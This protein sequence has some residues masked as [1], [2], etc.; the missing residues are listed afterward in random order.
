MRKAEKTECAD[1]HLRFKKP[2]MHEVETT[3]K[4]T[5]ETVKTTGSSFGVGISAASKGKR[6]NPRFSTRTYQGK[7][8][9]W[10]CNEC[11]QKRKG[12]GT[13]GKIKKLFKFILKL[14]FYM[15]LVGLIAGLVINVFGLE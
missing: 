13:G 6:R 15:L 2:S 9:E 1:C 14:Y 4:T 7:A 12:K 3:V 10:L 5:V 11:Y 8:T